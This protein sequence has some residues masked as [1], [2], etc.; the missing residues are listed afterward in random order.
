[1]SLTDTTIRNAKPGEKTVKLNTLR[2]ANMQ[3]APGKISCDSAALVF[4]IWGNR[5]MP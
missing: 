4:L 2:F 5:G 3:N 1:M